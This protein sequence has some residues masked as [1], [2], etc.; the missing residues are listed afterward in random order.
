VGTFFG[1]LM[2]AA[3]VGDFSRA[4]LALRLPAPARYAASLVGLLLLCGLNFM[5]GWELRRLSPVG[6]GRSRAM[7]VMVVVPAAVGTAVATLS[8]LPM[9]PA[10][11]FARLA[12]ASFWVFGA[13]GLLTSRSTPGGDGRTLRA[14]WADAAALAAAVVAVRIMAGGVIF[15]R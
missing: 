4:A 15:Q 10:L 1:N 13:A 2:S 9:P 3:F 7:V 12:E 5:V 6:S 14:G 8:Y 11:F